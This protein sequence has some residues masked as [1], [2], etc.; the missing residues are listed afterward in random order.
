MRLRPR[1]DSL[2]PS[3]LGPAATQQQ[4]ENAVGVFAAANVEVVERLA[5][6]GL[7]LPDTQ[8]VYAQA[9]WPWRST[10]RRA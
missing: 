8:A 10:A 1:Q 9:G 4:I 6:G 3:S 2:S 7:I 5:D